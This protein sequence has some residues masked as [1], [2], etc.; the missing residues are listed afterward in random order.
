MEVS[1]KV[2]RRIAGR[3]KRNDPVRFEFPLGGEGTCYPS[4]GQ[5]DAFIPDLR[6]QVVVLTDGYG[7]VIWMETVEDHDRRDTE[8]R[9]PSVVQVR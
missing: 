3:L 6:Q 4:D 8:C 1:G 2:L 5:P 7:G 9:E